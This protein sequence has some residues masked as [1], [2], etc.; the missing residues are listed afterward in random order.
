MSEQPYFFLAHFHTLI[1]GLVADYDAGKVDHAGLVEI[2]V[3]VVRGSSARAA[4]LSQFN[5]EESA[6]DWIRTFKALQQV[7]DGLD[8]L[9]DYGVPRDRALA[10]IAEADK[11]DTVL[12]VSSVITQLADLVE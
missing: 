9:D 3:G 12:E 2:L 1:D 5:N 6:M 10:V 11:N 7:E 4:E 8:R